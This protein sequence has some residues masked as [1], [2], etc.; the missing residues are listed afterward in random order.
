MQ[1]SAGASAPAPLSGILRGGREMTKSISWKFTVIL[2]VTMLVALTVAAAQSS[3]ANAQAAPQVTAEQ[4]EQLDQLNQLQAQLQK[5]RGAVRAAITQYGWDSDQ[6]DAAR[7][8]LFRDRAEYR[9]LRRSLCVAGVAVPPPAGMGLRAFRSGP[10][11]T[12]LGYGAGY[13]GHRGRGYGRG[14]GRRMCN[15]PFAF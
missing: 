9:G 8:K 2:G 3:S 5:D 15:C 6:T 7:A 13:T 12:C 14:Y 4:Q 10:R 1:P 11:G